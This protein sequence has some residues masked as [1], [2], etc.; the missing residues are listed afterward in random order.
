M[1]L[2]GGQITFN[3]KQVSALDDRFRLGVQELE[4]LRRAVGPLV[5]LTGQ[6]LHCEVLEPVQRKLVIDVV[7]HGFGEYHALSFRKQV[8]LY[9]ENVI[10]LQVPEVGDI[11]VKVLIQCGFQTVSFDL[12]ALFFLYKDTGVTHISL[13]LKCGAKIHFFGVVLR[14]LVYTYVPRRIYVCAKT[15]IRMRQGVYT[16][17]P[18]R[19]YARHNMYVVY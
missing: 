13:I 3:Y 4:A 7:G 15:Y 18:R 12:K 16:Y 9:I 8:F 2:V 11:E 1:P 17:A 5:E 14:Q 10:D 19:I 6:E